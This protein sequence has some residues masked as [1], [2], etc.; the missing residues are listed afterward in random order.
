MGVWGVLA[1]DGR[2]GEADGLGEWGRREFLAALAFWDADLGY[3]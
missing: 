3:R 1:R 2:V